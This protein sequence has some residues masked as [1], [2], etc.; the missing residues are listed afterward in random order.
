M[1]VVLVVL[2]VMVVCFAADAGAQ[3]AR[4]FSFVAIGDAGEPGGTVGAVARATDS[5]DARAMRDGFPVSTLLF[6]GDNFYPVGLNQPDAVRRRLIKGALDPFRNILQRLGRNNVHAIAGNHEYYCR[7]VGPV[8][9]G[10]CFNGNIYQSAIRSWTFHS[11]Y[12]TSIRRAVSDGSPDSVEIIMFDSGYILAMPMATWQPEF[13]SLDRMLRASAQ[14]SSVKWRIA[15]AHHSPYTVGEHGGYRQWSDRLQRV[16]YIGNCIDEGQ[17][18]FR[19]AYQIM[20]NA[21]NCHPEYQEYSR[22]LLAAFDRSP[23]KIQLMLAGHDHS[24]Q[25][26]RRPV[27]NGVNR[28]SVF[29]VSGAGAKVGMV[30]SPLQPNIFTHPINTTIATGESAAGFVVGVIRDDRIELEFINATDGNVLDMGGV[31]RFAVKLDG[32]LVSVD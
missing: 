32:E 21:D 5:Y 10:T 1:C 27:A 24:L 3:G 6:L 28:P 29:I 17:D 15:I 22:R 20:S 25:L 30:R 13:D 14:N 23:A 16:T 8:P 7:V 11:R 4:P 26:L 31:K 12:P 18:P 19:Y 2:V 9:L